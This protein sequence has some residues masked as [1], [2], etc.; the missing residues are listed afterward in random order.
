MKKAVFLIMMLNLFNFQTMAQETNYD[1]SKVPALSIPELL[2]SGSGDAVTDKAQWEKQRRPELLSTLANEVYGQLPNDLEKVEFGVSN[3]A[4]SAVSRSMQV[5]IKSHRQGKMH[6]MKL[7]VFLPKTGEGPFPVLLLISHRNV[8]E[9]LNEKDSGFFPI[10][11]I[12]GQGF[13]AAVFDVEDVAPDDPARFSDGILQQLYPD[14]LE[15]ADGMRGLSAWAWGAMRAM[16]YFVSEPMFDQHKAGVVGHSRGGKA[17]LWCGANDSRWALTV[18]NESGCGGAALSKRQFGETIQRINTGFPYWFADNFK[19]HNG[20]EA[21]MAFD[22]HMLLASIAPR[23]V[24][25]ASAAED[26]WA[27]PK[28]EYLA[29]RSATEVY[30]DIYGFSAALPAEFNPSPNVKHQPKI[31]YHLRPGKHDLTGYDWERF[32]EFFK[33]Y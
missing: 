22:Q 30:R 31:G 21:D 24:Y 4:V 3:V 32:M 26:L 19:K 33:E 11:K 2:V 12:I 6:E 20:K 5:L 8:G 7:H 14:H 18:S 13:A 27:D 10:A 16:D 15:R 28:G 9:L 23:A 25:V 1:E 29:L 17:A